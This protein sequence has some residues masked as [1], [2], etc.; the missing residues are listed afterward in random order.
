[1]IALTP[2]LKRPLVFGAVSGLGVAH[3]G[4]WLE[5]LWID[6]VYHFPWP[7]SIWPEALAMAVPVTIL[8]GVCGAMFGLVLDRSEVAV[9]GDQ[10]RRGRPDCPG[11]WRRHG[12]RP[13]L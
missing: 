1:M 7:T 3:H 6:A 5:S 4:L 11:H 9:P 8:I 10:Y 13:A 2:L 12:Q